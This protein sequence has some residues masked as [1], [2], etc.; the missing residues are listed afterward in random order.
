[1][2]VEGTFLWCL[3]VAVIKG[4]SFYKEVQ[5]DDES[6]GDQDVRAWHSALC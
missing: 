5:K 1:M 4:I 2:F 6:E 3:A